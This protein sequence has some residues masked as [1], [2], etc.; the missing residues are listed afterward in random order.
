MTV[1]GKPYAVF[2]LLA[3]VAGFR[4]AEKCRGQ[5]A[6]LNGVHT[7]IERPG[8]TRFTGT[9]D[10]PGIHRLIR[11]ADSLIR[12]HP[13]SAIALLEQAEEKS[14]HAGYYDGAALARI[15]TGLAATSTGDFKQSFLHY[16]TAYRYARQAKNHT[17]LFPLILIDI[18][19]IFTHMHQ[20]ERAAQH[21]LTVLDF[22]E[23]YIP[24]H[25]NRIIAYS[26]LAAVLINIGQYEQA[27]YY[28]QQAAA[29]AAKNNNDYYLGYTLANRGGAA[30]GR[31]QYSIAIDHYR[32][33]I[34]LAHKTG[35]KDLEKGIL[36]AIGQVMLAAGNPDSAIIYTKRAIGITTPG[37]SYNS[38]L[39]PYYTLGI[40]LHHTGRYREAEHALLKGLAQSRKT[41]QAEERA[42]ALNTLATLYGQTGRIREA[43]QYTQRYIQLKDS[44]LNKEKL[45]IITQLEVKYRTVQKDKEL[46]EKQ[47]MIIS[48]KRKIEQKNMWITGAATG[49]GLLAVLLFV[50]YRNSRHRQKIVALKA[51]IEGEE[52]ERTRIAQDLH[53]GIGGM[54]AA[55]QMRLSNVND[56][57]APDIRELVRETAN[58]V[59]KT[60]HN[61][62]PDIIQRYDLIE[63]LR[64]YCDKINRSDKG[65]QIEVQVHE[66]LP[67]PDKTRQLSLY[68]VIQEIVQNIVKHAQATLAVIQISHQHNKMNIIVEDNG[69]GFHPEETEYGL[70]IRNM[71]L[72]IHM[73]EGTLSVESAPGMGTTVNISIPA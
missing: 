51:M 59:R 50:Y 35:S 47:L 45:Q 71:Q 22:L 34:N 6:P 39:V 27:D 2:F 62:M 65:V 68:R 16:G 61:L 72:R 73:L 26:N 54:L 38:T 20:Y 32:K 21:Y 14:L 48:Q 30:L 41:D 57:D 42:E 24:E 37:H 60:A 15:K 58:E 64:I 17:Q 33:A 5:E 3:A 43:L 40:A 18:G 56:T 19:T 28:L 23:R 55:V 66:P 8:D 44:V 49:A 12:T 9:T 46:A 4:P 25:P 29:L 63:A 13:D 10:T 53:D 36:I 67:A 7:S 1:P 31:K 70:G 11:R 69:K 52:R